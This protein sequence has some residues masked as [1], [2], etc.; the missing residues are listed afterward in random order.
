M[1]VDIKRPD[2]QIVLIEFSQGQ[3]W[4]VIMTQMLSED[5]LMQEPGLGNTVTPYQIFRPKSS[6]T[7]TDSTPGPYLIHRYGSDT[8]P[9]VNQHCPRSRRVAFLSTSQQ[10]HALEYLIHI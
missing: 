6:Q 3:R 10:F 1:E 2:N 4:R 8:K 7:I 5:L 9:S